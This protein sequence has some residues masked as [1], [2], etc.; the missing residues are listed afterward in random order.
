MAKELLG[1][2]LPF[3]VRPMREQDIPAVMAIERVSF[4]SPWPESAYYYELRYGSGSIFY[5]LEAV[6]EGGQGRLS[7]SPQPRLTDLLGYA[8]MRFR[9]G[10]AHLS[11]IAIHPE[12]RGRGL[13]KFLLL[14]MLE[15]A[16]RHGA[17]R[18]TLEVRPSNQ[19][20]QRLYIDVGFVFTGVRPAYYRD[21]EDAWLM[22]L[23]P[24]EEKDI[25]RLR[26]MRRQVRMRI[27]GAV[28]RSE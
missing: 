4:P 1:D 16:L 20:A 12:W 26:A 3:V 9:G 6:G 14:T 23:G 24:L 2:G 25:V 17:R 13:G 19:V 11:T 22:S 5:V 10:T 27:E 8:G 18:V 7:G 28:R 21:G 15:E